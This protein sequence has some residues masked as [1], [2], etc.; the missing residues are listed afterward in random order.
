MPSRFETAVAAICAE[1]GW[2]PVPSSN[3]GGSARFALA[4]MEF[5]LTAPDDRHLCFLHPLALAL[6]ETPARARALARM[7]AAAA[8]TRKAV[9]SFHEDTF[10]L[11]LIVDL[12]ATRPEEIPAICQEF[13]N[14]CD[15]WRQN[16]SFYT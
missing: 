6:D 11:H 12:A 1:S 15:W 7:A 16:R 3:G 5:T 8:R 13:L 4:E 10:Y 2:T 14:D 9:L